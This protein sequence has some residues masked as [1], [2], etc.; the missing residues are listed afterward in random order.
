[1]TRPISPSQRP[2]VNPNLSRW[3]L[4]FLPRR[5]YATGVSDVNSVVRVHSQ[6]QPIFV[7]NAAIF[8]GFSHEFGSRAT[9]ARQGMSDG[10]WI[11]RFPAWKPSP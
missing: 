7:H 1:M 10:I 2:K 8:L 9:P 3:R 6:R 5:E 11:F 4:S